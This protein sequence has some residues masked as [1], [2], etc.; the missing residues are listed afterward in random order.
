M[1]CE[2]ARLLE[3]SETPATDLR[4]FVDITNSEGQTIAEQNTGLKESCFYL[5]M[6]FRRYYTR[7]VH[8]DASG[9]FG[10]WEVS[11][12]GGLV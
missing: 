9:F 4:V 1:A 11:A 12:P 2:V 5:E 3:V 7:A 8:L 10:G 6:G